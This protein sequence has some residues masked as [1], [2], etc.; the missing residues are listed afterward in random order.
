MRVWRTRGRILN[1]EKPQKNHD[2]KDGKGLAHESLLLL[3][4]RQRPWV[5]RSVDFANLKLKSK[6]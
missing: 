3:F 4:T 6:E 2:T 5:T 1:K